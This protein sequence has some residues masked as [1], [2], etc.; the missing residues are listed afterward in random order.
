MAEV[1][2]RSNQFP[3]SS[4]FEDFYIPCKK[5]CV[6]KHTYV[7]NDILAICF[8]NSISTAKNVVGELKRNGIEFETDIE[9]TCIDALVYFNSKD[10]KKVA[11][12]VGAKTNG[13]NI[14]PMSVRNLPKRSKV[15]NIIPQEKSNKLNQV[16]ANMDKYQKM[17]FFRKSNAEFIDLLSIQ[18]TTDYKSMMK[19]AGLNTREMIYSIGYWDK[20][21]DFI[22]DKIKNWRYNK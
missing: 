7:G 16:V 14:K 18:D 2:T 13:K 21:L 9:D 20:Y 5:N 19:A 12:I 3:D 8:Y 17:Q 6:I 1:D 4:S 10:L 15:H 11:E 22:S